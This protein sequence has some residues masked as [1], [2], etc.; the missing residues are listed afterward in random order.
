MNIH[1]ILDLHNPLWVDT[2]K[3]IR[4]DVYHLP[5]YLS[6]E[7]KR[8]QSIPEA[9]LI[10]NDEKIFFMPYLVRR[11]DNIISK[12]STEKEIF[13]VVSPYGYPGILLSKAA[14]ETPGFTDFALN[15]L[16]SVLAGKGVC[17]AFFRLH[18]I[19][20]ANFNTIVKP[21]IL[22]HSGETVSVDLKLSES[23]IW[24][25][26]R[27]GHQSTINK[28]KRLGLNPEIVPFSEYMNEFIDI[29][30]ET[31][32]RVTA[33]K[34]YYFDYDYFN[35]LSKLVN[36]N[37]C[38]VK[39]DK[40]VICASLIFENC[41]ITQAHL[42]GTRT[43]FLNKSP[44]NI[45]IHYVRLWAKERGNEFL[46]LGGGVGGSSQDKL[47]TFKSGFSRQRYNFLTLR[48]IVDEEKYLHLV[49]LRAKA[50][51]TQIDTLLNSSFFPA[52]RTT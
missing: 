39:L 43:E 22:T 11:C 20:N 8:T 14:R 50:L 1:K 12:E 49:N 34:S 30:K 52:Y 36:L 51:N 3:K 23:E 15:E 21:D 42:G 47:Y 45:L 5:E 35:D 26:T 38:I 37:L 46:H 6:I 17:S 10:I 7:A 33:E 29:Y 31:M 40:Q 19:L 13:D 4:H 25:H 18:P 16:T 41:G 27:K 24:A 9:F 32:S 28:C 48:L 44:F 2:L